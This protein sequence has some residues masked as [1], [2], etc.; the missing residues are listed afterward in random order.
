MWCSGVAAIMPNSIYL[1]FLFHWLCGCILFHTWKWKCNAPH[2][3]VYSGACKETVVFLCVRLC[4][5]GHAVFVLGRAPFLW[6]VGL[7][8]SGLCGPCALF[9]RLHARPTAEA[10]ALLL[11]AF[12]RL[13]LLPGARRVNPITVLVFN[14]VTGVILTS[15]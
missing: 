1:H 6:C 3:L 5:S 2:V 15:K 13:A 14:L 11:A 10:E 4:V 7:N 12:A 9:A 8:P